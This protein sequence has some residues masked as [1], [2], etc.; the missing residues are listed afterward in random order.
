MTGTYCRAP[1]DSKTAIKALWKLP[2]NILYEIHQQGPMS[3]TIEYTWEGLANYCL[4]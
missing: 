2:D 4:R 1:A 3:M